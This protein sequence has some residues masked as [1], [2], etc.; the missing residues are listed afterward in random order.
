ML[1]Q[2][3]LGLAVAVLVDA[4]VIRCLVVPAVLGLLGQRAW[5][6]PRWV[7]R[8]LPRIRLEADPVEASATGPRTDLPGLRRRV[9]RP[10]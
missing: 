5:W 9:G 3:G 8:L 10:R 6:L 4:V 7:G 2:M 1:Q